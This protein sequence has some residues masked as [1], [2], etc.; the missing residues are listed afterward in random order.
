MKLL[1]PILLC[2]SLSL[3]A[4]NLYQYRTDQPR[5]AT[6]ENPKAA[7][8][9]GGME[10][11]SAKGHAFEPI[12]AGASVTLLDVKGTGIVQRMWL[13]VSD[14]SPEMLRSLR[15]EMFW[16]GE[17][18]PAVSVPLG[19][20][21][22]IS[23]G[24]LMPFENALFSSP[25]GRSFNCLIPMPFR[26]GARI[27]V[28]ND[29]PKRLDLFFYD[30]DFQLVDKLPDDALYFH[31]H[32]RRELKTTLGKDF[33]LLPNVTGRGRFL[34]VNMG[35]ITAPEYGKSWW[36]EGEVKIY[37]DGD[38]QY[39][40]IVGTGAED[41]VGSGWG[42]GKF[43]QR[44]QGC[45]VANDSTRQWSIY[46]FH[47]DDALFFQKNMKATIQ[48]LGG[49]MRDDV[50]KFIA[51]KVPLIPVTVNVPK[52]CIKLL[53]PGAPKL[54]DADFP[55]GWVNFYRTEDYCAT[56]YFYLDKPVS[57]LPGLPPL[58]IRVAGIK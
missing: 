11:Q 49:Y 9:A 24:Q 21:F 5:W 25:E 1:L 48:V 10:N 19:D 32:W 52:G 36:G 45:P 40:T 20:F 46:R 7:R 23:H 51:D 38:G 17:A 44:M 57:G 14:R 8:G 37:L 47:L 16:D 54:S 43:I 29:S 33:E 35:L 41:Y 22:S 58:D 31:C 12:E 6:F 13:T 4:Q 56:A 27:V 30:V 18:K 42:L 15:L 28:T 2:L 39:P 34:G 3:H 26:K 55:D 50:R 53:E